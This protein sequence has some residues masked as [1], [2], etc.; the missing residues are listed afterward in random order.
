MKKS[1]LC[2]SE[3]QRKFRVMAR[4]WHPDKAVAEQRVPLF[5]GNLEDFG[6][7][8]LADGLQLVAFLH[9]HTSVF[10]ERYLPYYIE[11]LIEECF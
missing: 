3:V 9:L 8:C 1:E 2:S 10:G 5:L 7:D 4:H 6:G 11:G